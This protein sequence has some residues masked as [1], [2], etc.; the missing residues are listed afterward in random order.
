MLVLV[1]VLL[2]L[3][4]KLKVDGPALPRGLLW[5]AAALW[6]LIGVE[7][8]ARAWRVLDTPTS[9][10]A[11]AAVGTCELSGTA[12]ALQ[13]VVARA[14]GTNSFGSSGS[15]RN[16]ARA[17][18]QQLLALAEAYPRLH[19]DQQ[20]ERLA[21]ALRDTENRIA[22]SRTFYNDAVNVMRD[23]RGTFPYILVASFVTMPTLEL[24]ETSERNAVAV[25][26]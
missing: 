13:P 15:C 19:A 8:R 16:T 20:Y 14:S 24:F 6:F 7:L 25:G 2:F 4:V 26:I 22:L 18:A 9:K 17:D 3:S 5:G 10:V 11:G 1:G 21:D 23:R 12:I